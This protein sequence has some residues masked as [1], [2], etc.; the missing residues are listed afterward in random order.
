MHYALC[1][2]SPASIVGAAGLACLFVLAISLHIGKRA[3]SPTGQDK[4]HGLHL[5]PGPEPLPLIGNALDM[6]RKREWETLTK[7][8]HKYG[9]LI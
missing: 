5:P 9:E 1:E 4:R 6:P 7:W 2:L 3:H 8:A